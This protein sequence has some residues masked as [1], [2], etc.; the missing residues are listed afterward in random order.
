MIKFDIICTIN[1]GLVYYNI[2]VLYEYNHK[3][4]ILKCFF[5]FYFN[6]HKLKQKTNRYNLIFFNTQN[7]KKTTI[8][9]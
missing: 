7:L 1:D 4:R 3:L 8:F 6:L 2:L 9:F 5:T